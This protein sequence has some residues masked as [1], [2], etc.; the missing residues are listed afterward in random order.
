MTKL[1]RSA[2]VDG[3]KSNEMRP[4]AYAV[5]LGLPC[6]V[7]ALLKVPR[8]PWQK[9]GPQCTPTQHSAP[10]TQQCTPNRILRCSQPTVQ[11]ARPLA[12][13]QLTA[14]TYPLPP[15]QCS[16]ASTA[17]VACSAPRL[18]PAEPQAGANALDPHKLM[19]PSFT[20][21]HEACSLEDEDASLD[22]A[23]QAPSTTLTHRVRLRLIRCP[24]LLQT[25]Q[26]TVCSYPTHLIPTLRVLRSS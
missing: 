18:S 2:P 7:E 9:S 19:D 10:P 5:A 12:H 6:A 16:L 20:L 25:T 22:I 21:L 15:T 26:G 3:T 17:L 13:L 11:V 14:R 8:A 24:R 4:L 23:Q 1:L